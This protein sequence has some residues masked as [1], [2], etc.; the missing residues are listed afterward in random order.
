MKKTF[1]FCLLAVCLLAGCGGRDSVANADVENNLPPEIVS[2]CV[3]TITQNS[4]QKTTLSFD[5]KYADSLFIS[6]LDMDDK[7]YLRDTLQ[8]DAKQQDW[9]L[10]TNHSYEFYLR[11]K[12]Q[13]GTIYKQLYILND[14]NSG[15]WGVILRQTDQSIKITTVFNGVQI[16][17]PI[18]LAEVLTTGGELLLTHASSDKYVDVSSLERGVYTMKVTLQHGLVVSSN[19]AKR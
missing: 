9:L 18:T 5:I 7:Q 13:Y 10:E 15:I 11:A 4:K 14:V 12:N 19:F 16:D 17:Y 8:G 6:I 2:F 3:D 1:L